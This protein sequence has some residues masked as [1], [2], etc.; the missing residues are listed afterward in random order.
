LAELQMH[1]SKY[2]LTEKI[3]Q[4]NSMNIKISRFQVKILMK[5][6]GCLVFR[7]QQISN[8]EYQNFQCLCSAINEFYS[9][10]SSLSVDIFI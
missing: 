9:V 7:F 8:I 5:E 2:F 3:D 1:Q 4:F 6:A 10:F